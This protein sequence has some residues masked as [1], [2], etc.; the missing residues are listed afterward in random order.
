MATLRETPIGTARQ[1]VDRTALEGL[2]AAWFAARW[3]RG[4][5]AL[6]QVGQCAPRAKAEA[7]TAVAVGAVSGSEARH[8]LWAAAGPV[9]LG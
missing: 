2:S 3:L 7:L 9:G 6:V 1:I 5:S 4:R 8:L